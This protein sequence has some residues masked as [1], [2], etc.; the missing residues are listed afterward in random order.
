ML[1]SDAGAIPEVLE[2]ILPE[3]IVPAGSAA[4]LRAKAEA[5]LDG[6]LV[7]PSAEALVEH[8]H[9]R[10]DRSVIAPQLLELLEGR[11]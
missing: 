6:E 8:V 5:F 1:A 9:T 4:A 7:A 11:H 10:F 2:P 3:F